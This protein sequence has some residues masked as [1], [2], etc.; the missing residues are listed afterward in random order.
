MDA[1][2]VPPGAGG[3]QREYLRVGQR[4]TPHPVREELNVGL[5]PVRGLHV[6]LRVTVK[7]VDHH[8][9]DPIEQGF[10]AGYVVIHSHALHPQPCPETAHG[11]RP[12]A[13]LL[14]QLHRDAQ[15]PATVQRDPPRPRG[16]RRTPRHS[17][18]VPVNTH[19][20]SP[21]NPSARPVLTIPT[22]DTASNPGM[23]NTPT[24]GA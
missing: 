24:V 3:D 15:Y 10:P 8:L 14:D 1:P 5:P 12:Q 11:Q 13:L 21:A 6:H 19:R 2:R 17:A 4:D 7:L 18:P 23:I 9:H 20:N 22:G 16:G